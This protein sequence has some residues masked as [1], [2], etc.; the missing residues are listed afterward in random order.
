M[1]LAKYKFIVLIFYFFSLQVVPRANG[2]SSP[3]DSLSTV[4][5]TPATGEPKLI[6]LIYVIILLYDFD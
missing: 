1:A 2:Q 3:I 4:A 5:K 6:N